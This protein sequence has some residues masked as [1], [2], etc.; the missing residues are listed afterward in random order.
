MPQPV[1]LVKDASD[2]FD[3]YP[4]AARLGNGDLLIA[5]VRRVA[6]DGQ[7]QAWILGIR[8]AA[9]GVTW[10]EPF[11]LIDTPD[12]LDYD[13][14]IIAWDNKVMVIS[15][16]VPKTHGQQVTTSKFL[17]VRSED[18]GRTWSEPAEIPHPYTYCSG[19]INPGVRFADGTLAF[20]FCADINIERGKRVVMDGDSWG[21]SCV[22]ISTDDGHTWTPGQTVG[23]RE[24]VPESFGY[25]INGLDEPALAVCADGSLY[26]LMRS[27]FDRLYEALSRDQG[28]TWSDPRPSG[29][30]AHDCPADI[31]AFDDPKRG[32][33]W[34]AIYDHSP[35]YRYPLA[36][37]VSLDEART[38][39]KPFLISDVGMPSAYP[40][41]VQTAGGSVLLVWQ[42][43]IG[44]DSHLTPA[45]QNKRA[46]RELRACL[47]TLDE[48]DAIVGR[49][50]TKTQKG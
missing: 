47:L 5:Y 16:T 48:I 29:L 9:D 19:K 34:L 7:F 11:T 43:D 2:H 26:M 23:L 3:C 31:C 42:Q 6:A 24:E 13:P 21:E 25:A 35:K 14:N 10:S 17:A 49:P 20:G 41:C 37:A 1:T 32:H 33:G 15:T 27:G 8:S 18:N 38:W 12:M 50:G 36:V 30:T 4:C 28:R 46:S 22:M 40:A 39:S 44:V 45:G